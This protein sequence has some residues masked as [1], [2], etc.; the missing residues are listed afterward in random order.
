[1]DYILDF[2]FNNMEKTQLIYQKL[3]KGIRT[4]FKNKPPKVTLG[5]SGGLDSALVLALAYDALGSDADIKVLLMPSQFSSSH[6]VSDAEEMAKN[7]NI[8]YSIINIESL[9]SSFEK[10]LL[11][12][13]KGRT[14]DVTEENLQARIR[15]T[16]LMALSN[17]FGHYLLNTS[18]K[19]ELAMG[20]G[21]LYGDL[22]GALAVLGD[23]YKT[24]VYN[25]AKYINRK[26]EVIP[27]NII[28][29]APSAELRPEQKDTDSLPPYDILDNV[30]KCFLEDGLSLNQVLSLRYESKIVEKVFMALQQS[31]F[32][33]YQIPPIIKVTNRP[34]VPDWKCIDG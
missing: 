5:L 18:N 11:P 34:L 10:S 26:E 22:A 29:K 4:F 17:K 16:L 6:S 32:K 23:V 13:F 31:S 33:L 7:L 19:S 30:L 14:P 9:Y 2:Y 21:T 3:L 1:M 15:G 8:S 27:N 20:Y 25:I 12:L 24:D 28:T